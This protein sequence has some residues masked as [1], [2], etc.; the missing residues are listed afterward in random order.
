MVPSCRPRYDGLCGHTMLTENSRITGEHMRS[1]RWEQAAWVMLLALVAGTMLAVAKMPFMPD[2]NPVVERFSGPQFLVLSAGVG[3]ALVL[4]AI[5]WLRSETVVRRSAAHLA[6]LAFLVSAALSS[7][8]SAV[9]PLSI[10]GESGRYMGLIAWMQ[11]SI[12]FFLASQLVTTPAR[13]RTLA[14]LMIVVGTIEAVIALSQVLGVDVLRFTFPDQYAWMLSQGVGTLG[15]PNHLSTLLVIPFMLAFATCALSDSVDQRVWSGAAA[16]LMTVALVA[17][18]T[19]AAWIG[20]LA[21]VALL[22]IIG[23]RRGRIRRATAIYALLLL[24]AA[25]M[26]GSLVADNAIMRTRFTPDGV[27]PTAADGL[28]SG[29]ITIWAQALEV[30]STN[31]VLG[32]GADSLRNAWKAG[33]LS[34]GKIGVF[35]DDPHSLPLLLANSFGLVGLLLFGAFGYLALARPRGHSPSDDADATDGT[36]YREV[37]LA[38]TLALLVTSLLSVMSIPTLL[39]LMLAAGTV[40]AGS[41][42]PSTA[43]GTRIHPV[44]VRAG[45]LVLAAALGAA[46]ITASIVPLVHNLRI[47]AANLDA[48]MPQS[49]ITVLDEAD[50]ALPW[51]YEMMSRRA[52]RLTDQGLYEMS[53]GDSADGHGRSRLESLLSDVDARAQ[54]YEADYYA[55]L[56]RARTY[57]IVADSLQDEA[58]RTRADEITAEALRRFPNDLDLE[59]IQRFVRAR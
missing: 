36:P 20:A 49:S 40:H 54:R 24:S 34:S 28:S 26:V 52:A 48:P 55:W 43:D 47:T 14:R 8:L 44:W 41:G 22:V 5:A 21:G 23:L 38:A 29:R 25:I 6:L 3:I 2:T 39:S 19:R 33:G 30:M 9:V 37:W 35:T 59:E 46:G 56:V 27:S 51:R 13:A 50:R 11:A 12:V 31:P 1:G 42:M 58:L 53:V 10:V 15:N 45:V 18:A 7:L 4:W 16:A 57:A 32:V 17:S